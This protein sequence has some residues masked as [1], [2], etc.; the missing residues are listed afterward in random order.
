[1]DVGP[2]EPGID[3]EQKQMVFR[4]KEVKHERY[5]IQYDKF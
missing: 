1:V 2:M 3:V 4:R 5:N